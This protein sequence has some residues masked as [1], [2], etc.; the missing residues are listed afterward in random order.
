MTKAQEIKFEIMGNP[1]TNAEITELTEALQ[2]ARSKLTR[3]VARTLSPGAQVQFRSNRNGQV[4][5]GTIDSIKIKN[6]IVVTAMGRY[7]VPMN[8]LETV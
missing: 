7:R 2:Y 4:Y 5:K 1:F 6:A 3:S 8:M